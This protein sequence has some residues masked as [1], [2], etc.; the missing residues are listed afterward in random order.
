ML[1]IYILFVLGSNITLCIGCF[2]Y[3]YGRH[4]YHHRNRFVNMFC[5]PTM[6]S[7]ATSENVPKGASDRPSQDVV[8]ADCGEVSPYL[9]MHVT[10]AHYTLNPSAPP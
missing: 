9:T 2:R 3:R 5:G 8:I 7:L 6:I 10:L 4:G 1:S